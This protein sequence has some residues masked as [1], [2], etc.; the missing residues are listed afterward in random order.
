MASWTV[1]LEER[2]DL[3]AANTVMREQLELSVA[4]QQ[5]CRVVVDQHKQQL[6]EAN[7]QL[8]AAQAA[9]ERE[10]Q[11][12]DQLRCKSGRAV[13]GE[14]EKLRQVQELL[15]QTTAELR[16]RQAEVQTMREQHASETAKLKGQHKAA[17]RRAVQDLQ[18]EHEQAMDELRLQHQQELSLIHISEPTRLLSI[19][20]AVFCLKKKKIQL[21]QTK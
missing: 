17:L 2:T 16:E 21:T 10:H 13:A 20:Y 11:A 1:D 18:L 12:M 14:S 19:S 8:A 9:L 3:A 5:R 7:T 4:N 6:H 15:V